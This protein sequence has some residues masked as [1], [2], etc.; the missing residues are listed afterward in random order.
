MA[1][2]GSDRERSIYAYTFVRA[3]FV[4]VARLVADDPAGVLGS[5]AS[6]A[7]AHGRAVCASLRV[8]LGAFEI[9][10]EA[11]ID[12]GQVRWDGNDR[13]QV[14]LRWRDATSPG[15]FPA[16]QATL[17]VWGLSWRPPLVAVVGRYRPPWG[18][19]GGGGGCAGGPSCGRG[20]AGPVRGRGGGAHPA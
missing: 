7:A 18:G 17:E 2:D 15:L 6:V 10:R 14:A 16:V 5:A 8:R 4:E 1:G 20:D 19:V 11:T 13:V 3:P 9:G 12:I